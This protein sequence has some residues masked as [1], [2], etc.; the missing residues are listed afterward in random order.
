MATWKTVASY[1]TEFPADSVEWCPIPPY[2]NHFIC[3]TYYLIED[4]PAPEDP[5]TR[6]GSIIL[7]N[8]IDGI[9]EI[10]QNIK[11]L[12]VLDAKWCPYKLND[13]VILGVVTAVGDLNIYKFDGRSLEFLTGINVRSDENGD[14]MALSLNWLKYGGNRNDCFVCC[15]DNQGSVVVLKLDEAGF[16]IVNK[17]KAHGLEVWTAAFASNDKN[18]LYSGTFSSQTRPNNQL[19]NNKKVIVSK[20]AL[21]W[22]QT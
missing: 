10:T 20:H 3:G 17:W 7:M 16:K 22:V 1:E 8:V 2:Q 6:I 21:S 15:S 18:I 11:S 14:Y 5:Q 4:K 19:I 13:Q 12:G 9:L